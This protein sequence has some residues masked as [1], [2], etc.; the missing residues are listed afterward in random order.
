ME[1]QVRFGRVA[2]RTD[3]ADAR[4]ALNRVTHTYA[5]AFPLQVIVERKLAVAMIDNNLVAANAWRALGNA[6]E[7]VLL[8]TFE[9]S[10]DRLTRLLHRSGVFALTSNHIGD[11]P[12]CSGKNGFA[13]GKIVA[14]TLAVAAMS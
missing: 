1:V 12:G 7:L 9:V 3:C 5:H 13:L 11:M 4:T 6:P 2:R 8:Q 10:L 14:K